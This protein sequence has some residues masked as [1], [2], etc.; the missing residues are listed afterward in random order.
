MHIGMSAGT[1]MFDL[2]S[3]QR[4]L[5]LRNEVPHQVPHFDPDFTENRG[6]LW[7]DSFQVFAMIS[8]S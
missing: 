8:R 5:K 6:T 1:C 3:R 7:L 2:E 4:H